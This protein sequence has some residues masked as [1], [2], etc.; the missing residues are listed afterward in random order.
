MNHNG[1]EGCMLGWGVE[2]P[3]VPYGPPF[4]SPENTNPDNGTAVCEGRAGGKERRQGRA[5]IVATS[6]ER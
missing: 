2:K 3:F 5:R 1:S 6:F 4:V